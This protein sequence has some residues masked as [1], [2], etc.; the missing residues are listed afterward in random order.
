MHYSFSVSQM[1]V[2][3][4]NS[5]T[6]HF[7]CNFW[8]FW[9]WKFQDCSPARPSIVSPRSQMLE[10][11]KKNRLQKNVQ[12]TKHC[13]F[14]LCCSCLYCTVCF[15]R[16]D[17]GSRYTSYL[18]LG[19]ETVSKKTAGWLATVGGWTWP[20]EE[21]EDGEEEEEGRSNNTCCRLMLNSCIL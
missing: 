3:K 9:C 16:D 20:T 11:N 13:Y 15:V 2:W 8:T 5:K 6:T 1:W 10:S 14:F 21:D 17:G 19:L 7:L 18:S 12:T 4:K